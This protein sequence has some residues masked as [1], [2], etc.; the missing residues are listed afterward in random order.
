MAVR[1]I[2]SVSLK[3]FAYAYFSLSLAFLVWGLVTFLGDQNLLNLS[4]I[5]GNILLLLSTIFLLGLLF[6]TNKLIVT[7]IGGLLSFIFV[8]WRT[9]YFPPQPLISDGVLVFNTQLP[10]ATILG[11]ILL[12]VWLPTNIKVANLVAKRLKIKG[13]PFIYSSV[14]VMATLASLLFISARTIPVII[15]SFVGITLCFAMLI[16]SNVVIDK[17]TGEKNGRN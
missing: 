1:L 14:Y 16:A 3:S 9:T 8:W 4:V 17:V 5:S 12:L 11:L 10:V 7:T 15:L 13:M 2:H 6:E